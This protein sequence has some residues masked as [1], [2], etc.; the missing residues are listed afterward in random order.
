MAYTPTLIWQD[1]VRDTGLE[2][3][4]LKFDVM[5]NMFKKANALNNAEAH[6]ARTESRKTGAAKAGSSPQ[7]L[8]LYSAAPESASLASQYIFASLASQYIF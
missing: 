8:E 2:T 5:C 7:A 6:A 3:K 1:L 4:D